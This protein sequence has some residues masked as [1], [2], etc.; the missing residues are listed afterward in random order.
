MIRGTPLTRVARTERWL[1]VLYGN[2][3]WT[4]PRRV[5]CRDLGGN[6][7][8][9]GFAHSLISGRYR[10]NLVKYSAVKFSKGALSSSN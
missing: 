7:I 9:I 10:N 1:Q 6:P 8:K 5:R 4:M 2:Q 3:A